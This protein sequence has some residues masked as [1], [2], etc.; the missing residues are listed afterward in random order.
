MRLR[1]LVPLL[2]VWAGLSLLSPIAAAATVF[3]PGLRVGLE[4]PGDLVVSKRFAGFEDFDRKVAITILDLPGRAYED[5]ERSVF[6]KD[7][8]GLTIV[9]RE[10]FPFGAGV[11]ILVTGNSVED[12]VTVHKWF[13]LAT[14]TGQNLATLVGVQV[15]EPALKVYSD[16]AVRKELK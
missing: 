13:L 4:P 16:A 10:M 15:P 14:A 2:A 8:K 5:I 11:G 12:G 1:L 6:D 3:P 9:K 7:H